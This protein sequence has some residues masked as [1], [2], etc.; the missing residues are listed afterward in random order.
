MVK[1]KIFR[2]LLAL[3]LTG[4][5]SLSAFAASVSAATRTESGYIEMYVSDSYKMQDHLDAVREI[6]NALYS[7]SS[8]IDVSSFKIPQADMSGLYFGTLASHPDLFFV[9]R[10]YS[11][12]NMGGYVYQI[13][14]SYNMTQSEAQTALESFYSEADHY[15][16]LASGKLSRC[17][18]DFSRAVTLHDEIVL[19]A[20]YDNIDYESDNYR[21]MMQKTGVCENYSRI[22][23]YLLSQLGMYS[24]I[25]DSDSMKHEWMLAKLDGSYYHVD[26]TWDDPVKDRPGRVSHTYFLLS[27]SRISQSINGQ[28][29]HS[30]YDSVHAALNSKYDNAAYHDFSSKLCKLDPSDTFVYGI[31]SSGIVRYNYSTN[32]S[33]TL[34]SITDTWYASGNSGSYYKGVYSGLAQNNDLLYYNTPSAVYSYDAATGESTLVYTNTYS[35]KLYGLYIRDAVLYGVFA[36]SPN[37]TGT[38]RQI[39]TLPA[40]TGPTISVSSVTLSK[41][42]LTLE[43][44]QTAT[45]TATVSP[46]DAA[47]KTITWSSSDTSVASVS[48]GTITAKAAGTATITARSNNGKTASVAVTVKAPVIDVTSVTLSETSLELEAG[49]SA[50]VTATVAPSNATDKTI[51]WSSSNTAVA[52]VS[53]GKITA[54]AA[55]TATITASSTNGKTASVAVTVTPAPIPVT[56]IVLSRSTANLLEGRSTTATATIEPSDA[57]D[58]T[59]TWTSSDTSIATV[60]NGRITAVAAGKATITAATSNGL[61]ATVAVTVK[62]AVVEV[63][64]VEL[65]KS[66]ANLVIDH[67]TTVKATVSPADATNKTITWTS[68]DTSVA[69]VTG[70]KITA[71]GGG[72]ATITAESNNG[73]TASLTVK[74]T[75]PATGITLSKSTTNLVIG[76]STTVKATVAPAD[77]TN[78]TVKWSSFDTSVATVS[79]GRITAVGGGTATI[80]ARTSNG[81]TATLTVKVSVPATSITLSKSTVNLAVDHSTTVKAT[82][83]PA[84]ATNKTVKWTSSDTSVAIVSNGKIT[85]LKKGTA[86]VTATTSNGLKATVTVNVK[87]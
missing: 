39:A 41:T 17:G 78:K 52:S 35:T 18:D 11:W 66:T 20:F 27:D 3:G 37:E 45:V 71:V 81:L 9:D 82:V 40:E 31:N 34:K 61:T 83:A 29:A 4:A 85:A 60:S 54:K 72:T 55:G 13:Y 58:K 7:H 15:L 6:S 70:G 50:T 22:Y 10:N 76:H 51:T 75:V 86:T 74:V 5:L 26:A 42:S 33:T 8:R 38:V 49:K 80:T 19:D 53:N 87:A 25:V 12:N 79:N 65:S 43:I 23:A 67:S 69:T 84:D 64:S 44:G 24:E 59:V 68:S 48:N 16:A 1:G 63:T 32:T 14:P 47:D 56:S 30:G 62:P 28:Q 46:S 73:I 57:T 2:S 21:F 36:S 77:A